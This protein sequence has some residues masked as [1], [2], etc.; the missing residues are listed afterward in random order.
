M[1]CAWQ[2]LLAILP[3][4]MRPEVDKLGREDAQELRLRL[5]RPVELVTH[6][7]SRWLPRN[8]SAQDISF[9]I[10][11]ASKYSPWA[12]STVSQGYIT[13]PGGHRIGMCGDA[14]VKADKAVGIR[15]ATSLCIRVAR[16]FP[17]IAAR[18]LEISGNILVI[19]PPGSG[20][21]TL[22][23]D[24]IRQISNSG[25]SITVVDE[26]GELFPAGFD[27]GRRTDVLSGCAKSQGLSMAMRT[28]GPS[29]IA[30]DEITAQSDCQALLQ[31]G[32]CGVRLLATAHASNL[33][34]LKSRP[35]YRP[36]LDTRLFD[37]VLVLRRD[38]TW[39]TER[40]M[41]C[42]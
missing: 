28:M 5:G 16:D 8:I 31:C 25:S 18:A 6:S 37:N 35:V 11:T 34:D 10:Q 22:L 32:W 27:Q 9:V 23:R 15:T 38:K 39:Y 2:E 29:C 14:V 33:N 17:G 19:G 13:A 41:V 7:G 20:K 3:P 12:A 26:R 42:L 40:M 24:L 1:K 36:L 4:A 21:T 30:V